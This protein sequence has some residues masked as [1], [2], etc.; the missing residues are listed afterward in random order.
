MDFSKVNIQKILEPALFNRFSNFTPQDFE[1]FVAQLFIDNSYNVQQ[2]KYSGDFGVDLIAKKS[3]KCLAIQIKRYKKSNKVSVKDINQI[4][5]GKEYYNCADALIITTSSFTKPA[6]KLADKNNVD[7]WDWNIFQKYVCDTYLDGKDFFE[8]FENQAKPESL[9]EKFNIVINRIQYNQTM[10][11]NEVAT[12]I[13]FNIIN[14]TNQNTF[15]DIDLPTFVTSDNHQIESTSYLTGYFKQCVLYSG[16]KI[17]C[18]F[19]FNSNQLPKVRIGDKLIVNIS[20][21]NYTR[22]VELH[23]PS[24]NA[25]SGC[26]MATSAF[27]SANTFEVQILKRWRDDSLNKTKFGRCFIQFYYF[28]GPSIAKLLDHFLVFKSIIKALLKF[29]AIRIY[30]RIN[31]NEQK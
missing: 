29:I 21:S 15:I 6:M 18:C 26:F 16:C 17:D 22:I 9:V 13:Y 14:Q 30:K 20:G 23:I 2:T 10:K 4:F 24:E 25:K 31:V 5:G 28:I 7:L 1:D 11:G 19:I 12:L 3:N 8:F 27:N